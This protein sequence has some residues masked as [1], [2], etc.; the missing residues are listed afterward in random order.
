MLDEAFSEG[1][2]VAAVAQALQLGEWTPELLKHV[3]L[4]AVRHSLT[5]GAAYYLLCIDNTPCQLLTDLVVTTRESE[6]QLL[7]MSPTASNFTKLYWGYLFF[8]VSHCLFQE[9]A[10]RD[11]STYFASL[12]P[13]F[14]SPTIRELLQASRLRHNELA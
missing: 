11:E 1:L 10:C 2:T 14:R 6:T 8:H 4:R 7:H 5:L 9:H 13:I 12:L 3:Q